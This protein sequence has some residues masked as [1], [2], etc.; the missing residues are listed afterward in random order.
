MNWKIATLQVIFASAMFAEHLDLDMLLN[1]IH[2]KTDLSEKTKLA[3]GGISFVYTRDD[4]QRM[5][6]RFL[7][8]ILKSTYPYG[9]NE[10]KFG[11][12]DPLYMGTLHPFVS[13]TIRVFIDNQEI[14][15]SLYGSGIIVIGDIDIDF[16]D[17][18][19]VYTQNPS[20]EFS[21]EPTFVLIK[22][23][24]KSSIKD[25]GSRI[26]VS[27]TSNSG[28]FENFQNAKSLEKWSYF[29]YLS[30]RNL[31]SDSINNFSK[32]KKVQHIFATATDGFNNFMLQTI[33]QQRDAFVNYSLNSNQVQSTLDMDFVH[34]GW[35][36]KTDNF[37]YNITYDYMLT[38][39]DFINTLG[40]ANSVD[41]LTQ[42]EVYTA[43]MKYQYN[44]NNNRFLT[45]LKYRYKKFDYKN[46][47]INSSA[48]KK[49]GHTYQT[50]ASGFLENQYS[51]K[52]STILTTGL[53]YS[54]IYN[55]HSITKDDLLMYRL[56]LTHTTSHWT[57]KTVASQTQT[58]LDPYLVNSYQTSTNPYGYIVDGDKEIQNMRS[59][60]QNIIFDN[61]KSQYE[62]IIS[63]LNIK[64]YLLP[65]N[66]TPT[67]VLDN[68][69]N[70]VNTYGVNFKY[71]QEYNDVDKLFVSIDYSQTHDYPNIKKLKKYNL[72]IRSTNSYKNIDFFNEF[73]YYK[74]NIEN[75]NFYDYGL[76]A[77]YYMNG[78]LSLFVKGENIFD[79]AKA[80]N[81]E[82][83][84]G[85]F[86]TENINLSPIQ[87]EFTIGL[88]YLF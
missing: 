42:S 72:V 64:N 66:T 1:N 22:L 62:M 18:I 46:L 69:D 57:F 33:R 35:D 7:K 48:I 83:Y 29:T 30:N 68:Y 61:G 55:D 54:N 63:K 80:N 79:K 81:Y 24:S 40:I 6:A 53:Q 41:S 75:K 23:Y 31:D 9:Y 52:D 56:G 43:E 36:R 84:Y 28:H 77:K 51:V 71:T 76:G 49:S 58:S 13:S 78:D 4:I 25:E 5:Q 14:T 21:T 27:K 32:D 67:A 37:S 88:E 3:N 19:E 65:N 59:L 70:E 87:K 2:K 85:S 86:S 50:V 16:V 34:L 17:H 74:D 60:L 39:S 47:V 45:G 10:N 44:L 12:S 15:T 82:N 38:D 26:S 8:D 11:L 20:Y 73:L